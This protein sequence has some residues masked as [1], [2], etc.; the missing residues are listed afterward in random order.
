MSFDHT[1]LPLKSDPT[2]QHLTGNTA[3]GNLRIDVPYM[4]EVADN[5]WHG[6][7]MDGLI[8]PDNIKHLVSLYK[9]EKYKVRHELLSSL[10]VEMFDSLDQSLDQIDALATWV[11]VC[12][13]SGPVLVHCQAGLNRSSLVVGAALVKSG[14]SGPEAVKMIREKRSEACLCNPSFESFVNGL[15][16]VL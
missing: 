1:A 4:T 16:R 14:L 8:L 15:E 13:E 3:H 11:N 2:R 7:C 9:W 12:R 10:T 5:L 6:G